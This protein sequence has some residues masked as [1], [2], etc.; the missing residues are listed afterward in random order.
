MVA[1]GSLSGRNRILFG[2]H[3]LTIYFLRTVF[4]ARKINLVGNDHLDLIHKRIK[5]LL[6]LNG[7]RLFA[8]VQEFPGQLLMT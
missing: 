5:D 6:V 3:D 2:I 4:G 1:L 7:E 8:D